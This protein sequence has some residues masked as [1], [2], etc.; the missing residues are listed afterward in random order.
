VKQLIYFAPLRVRAAAAGGSANASNAYK[1]QPI[2]Y[3]RHDDTAR[4][5]VSIVNNPALSG[6]ASQLEL[7]SSRI[8]WSG[9]C[10]C[11]IVDACVRVR[12]YDKENS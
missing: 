5:G 1:H 8:E 6:F 2:T 7:M 12:A 10:N 11:S 4:H 3:V 9:C